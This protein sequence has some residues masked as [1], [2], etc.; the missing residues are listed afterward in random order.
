MQYHNLLAKEKLAGSK[1]SAQ[2]PSAALL[3]L[4]HIRAAAALMLMS[5]R[6][7]IS[8]LLGPSNPTRHAHA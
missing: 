2:A 8:L 4:T 5:R 3:Y 1:S 6:L 7:K